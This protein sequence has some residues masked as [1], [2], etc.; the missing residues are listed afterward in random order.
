MGTTAIAYHHRRPVATTAF[1]RWAGQNGP[2]VAWRG[3]AGLPVDSYL[4]LRY[5]PFG[6][7]DHTGPREP[8]Q[9]EM[10]AM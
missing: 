8:R 6:A 2:P 4:R 3:A 1:G 10:S 7:R 5:N 9:H